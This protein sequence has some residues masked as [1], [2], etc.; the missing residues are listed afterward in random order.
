MTPQDFFNETIA[1][2]VNQGQQALDYDDVCSYRAE[3]ADGQTLKCAVG[4]WIPDA[5]YDPAYEGMSISWPQTQT[6]LPAAVRALNPHLLRRCQ[7]VHDSAS[8]WGPDGFIGWADVRA[9]AAEFGLSM[10][11]VTPPKSR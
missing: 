7:S 4:Y 11:P 2:L 3:A 1:H 9:T 8:C 6:M 5:D 10:P